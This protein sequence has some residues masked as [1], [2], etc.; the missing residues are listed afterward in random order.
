MRCWSRSGTRHRCSSRTAPGPRSRP[1]PGRCF[2][3]RSRWRAP[4]AWWSRRKPTP[5]QHDRCRWARRRWPCCRRRT[6]RRNALIGVPTAPCRPAWFPAGSRHLPLLVQTHAAPASRCRRSL[7]RWPCCRRRTGTRNSLVERSRR[8]PCRPAWFPAGSRLRRSSSR[9]TRPQRHCCRST[10]RRWPCCR[11]RRGTTECLD[12]A[13]PTAPVPTSLVPCWVQ[14]PPLLVQTHAAP[15]PLLSQALRRWPCCRRRRGTRK[16][17]V[18]GSPRRPCRPAWFPAGSRRLRSSSRPTRPQ[19]HR[20]RHPS[21]DGRVAVG[22]EGHGNALWQLPPRPCR[23][24]WCPAGSRHLRSSSRPTRPRERAVVAAR[25]RW[26]CCR[27][28]RGTRRCLAGRPHG[29]RADQLGSLLGPDAAAPRPDPRGPSATVVEVPADD[30]R[31]AVG[32]ERRRKC[33]VSGPT[34]PEPTSLGP[35]CVQTPPLRSRPTRPRRHRC[36]RAR[37]RWPCCRRRRA[38]EPC[39]RPHSARADQ[40]GPCWVQTPPLVSR[41]TPP[42]RR[43]CRSTRRRWPCCRRRR[44]TRNRLARRSPQRPCRP[45]WYPAGSR[46]LRSVS[47][48][49]PPQRDALSAWPTHEGRVAV[50]GERDGRAL[51]CSPHV[52]RAD[53]LASLLGPDSSAAREDPRRPGVALSHGPPTMAVLPSATTRPD[54]P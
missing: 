38:T 21:D 52:A 51:L 18:S 49:T 9:P 45:A 37:P 53:Q 12:R 5:P 15:A 47:R 39:E 32:G 42:R 43:G 13:S 48:P 23:P 11:R 50:G 36:R 10:R 31:V 17:L 24:A 22:G 44:A 29:A 33:L 4:V 26:P 28:R 6:G 30:G 8:R 1:A 7:R 20:C 27:R 54:Q 41:P 16:C 14:T 35:C 40:L 34:A 2:R 3:A 46:R 19:R 25:R